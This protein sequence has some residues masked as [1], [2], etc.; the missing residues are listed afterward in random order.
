MYL[1]AERRN[2]LSTELLLRRLRKHHGKPVY[3]MP[4]IIIPNPLIAAYRNQLPAK[5]RK[6]RTRLAKVAAVV[7]HEFV[8][9]HESLFA[10]PNRQIAA[11]PRQ[12]AMYLLSDPPKDAVVGRLLNRDPTCVRLAR[13]KVPRIASRDRAFA[14]RLQAME[15]AIAV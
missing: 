2:A 13:L 15:A 10:A 5:L 7:C 3:P 11:F 9:P 12:V 8:I 4:A 14:K 1:T 6:C